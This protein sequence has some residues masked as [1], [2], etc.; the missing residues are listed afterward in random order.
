MATQATTIRRL[1]KAAV[2]AVAVAAALTAGNVLLDLGSLRVERVPAAVAAVEAPAPL[3][4]SHT[5]GR[6]VLELDG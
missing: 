4:D 2:A 6:F 1:G 3:A 5:Q